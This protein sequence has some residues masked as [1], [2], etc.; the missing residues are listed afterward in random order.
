MFIN[1]SHPSELKDRDKRSQASRYVYHAVKPHRIESSRR[2]RSAPDARPDSNDGTPA[3]L[4][5]FSILPPSLP[6]EDDV[7]EVVETTAPPLE[8]WTSAGLRG[9]PFDAYPIR[10]PLVPAAVDYYKT[11]YVP[12]HDFM[13]KGHP[14]PNPMIRKTFPSALQSPLQF[15]GIVL[16]MTAHSK[17]AF[18]S[19]HLRERALVMHRISVI[20][21]LNSRIADP[22]IRS[23]N[24]TLNMTVALLAS[25]SLRSRRICVVVS[26]HP[27]STVPNSVSEGCIAVP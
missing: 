7:Q 9:D 2:N 4:V 12:I 10:A 13:F 8:L 11:S 1:Y 27:T 21:Q 15:E 14:A 16:L 5:P 18:G 24:V 6:A 23:D 22:L 3:P 19:P 26:D 17:T 25:V 20:Q